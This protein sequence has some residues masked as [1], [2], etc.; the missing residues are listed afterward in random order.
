MEN[1]D[2]IS[3]TP[4]CRLHF[5]FVVFDLV[6]FL[7]VATECAKLKCYPVA[8]LYSLSLPFPLSLVCAFVLFLI[9]IRVEFFLLFFFPLLLLLPPPFL[10]AENDAGNDNDYENPSDEIDKLS[11]VTFCFVL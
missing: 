10:C 11:Q 9:D 2:T 7:L 4:P 3:I 5:L 1:C 8:H 6:L